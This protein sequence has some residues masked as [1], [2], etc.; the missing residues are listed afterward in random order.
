[1]KR[2]QSWPIVDKLI[3]GRFGTSRII[4]QPFAFSK[5]LVSWFCFGPADVP[6]PPSSEF[7]RHGKSTRLGV[8]RNV[9]W[10]WLCCLCVVW[11]CRSLSLSMS[12]GFCNHKMRGLDY[13][14]EMWAEACVLP[15]HQPNPWRT[16]LINHGVCYA[17]NS[18]QASES[19]STQCSKMPVGV[20][21]WFRF[22]SSD[23]TR[24]SQNSV[25]PLRFLDSVKGHLWEQRKNV[26]ERYV[27]ARYFEKA[28]NAS[29]SVSIFYHFKQ[30]HYS[31]CS[32]Q[33]NKWQPSGFIL[34]GQGKRGHVSITRRSIR[35]HT[36]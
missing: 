13:N 10:S 35:N 25:L 31:V 32:K 28:S 34:I 17:V 4:V 26:L 1:M 14:M 15:P 7:L 27:L 3:W 22:Y 21:I 19:F 24:W 23:C 11:L 16:L 33:H 30:S 36:Y 18:E 6:Y 5:L 2:P 20:G 8:R 12:V 29:L 9:S